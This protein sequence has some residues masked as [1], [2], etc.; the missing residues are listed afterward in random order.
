[1]SYMIDIPIKNKEFLELLEDCRKILTDDIE[2]FKKYCHKHCEDEHDEATRDKWMS[3]KYLRHLIEVEGD[4]HEGF[5]DHMVAYSF[6]PH[7]PEANI[8]SRDNKNPEYRSEILTRVYDANTK[9]VNF[10]GAKNNALFSFYPPGG[11]ISWHNNWNACAY[12]L[13]CTWS[14]TG[15]G[16]FKYRNPVT[17]EIITFEDVPG[18]QVKAGYFGSQR[19]KDKVLY[20]AAQTDCWRVTVSFIWDHRESSENLQE[21]L[22][23][24]ISNE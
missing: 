6:K 17:G 2:S 23:Y 7:Q 3:E 24:E 5:P 10:L 14:E 20:H 11:Y 19:E 21:D 9:L 22:V 1:M 4:R 13:I 18:W 16:W 12:N 8:F 15:E